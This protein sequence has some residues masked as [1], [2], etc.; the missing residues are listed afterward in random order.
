MWGL[1]PYWT[2]L[3]VARQWRG[4]GP[5][6]LA[7]TRKEVAHSVDV[8]AQ[9]LHWGFILISIPNLLLILGMLVVFVA[10]LVVPFPHRDDDGRQDGPRHE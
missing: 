4:R 9:Y 6:R 7:R 10:A 5:P 8:P 3:L 2:G 1:C